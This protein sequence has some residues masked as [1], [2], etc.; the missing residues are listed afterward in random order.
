VLVPLASTVALNCTLVSSSDPLWS[1]DLAGDSSP[2]RFQ[3]NTH[4]AKLN[5]HGLYELPS[6][7]DHGTGMI[8]LRLLINNTAVN[9]Q[10]LINCAGG[11]NES[12]LT[13]VFVFGTYAVHV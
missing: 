9:N 11:P 13:T 8:T 4:S 7:T 5:A 2:V 10:T 6:V 1:V 3:F 12:F